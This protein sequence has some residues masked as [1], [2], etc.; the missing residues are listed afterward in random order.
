MLQNSAVW[1]VILGAA[2][3][4]GCAG[5]IEAPTPVTA[6]VRCLPPGVTPEFF[7]WPV[8]AFRPLRLPRADGGSTPAAWVLYKNGESEVAVV[9]SG[10]DLVAIDPSPRTRTSIWVDSG[11][12]DRDEST[13]Q[14]STGPCQWRRDLPVV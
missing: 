1:M 5:R 10:A 9:W 7:S 2:L 8:H 3:M 13:R 11:L 4:P 14:A 12:L 6:E